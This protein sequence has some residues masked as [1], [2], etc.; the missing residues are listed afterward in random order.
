[1]DSLYGL[2]QSSPNELTFKV[3]LDPYA[4]SLHGNRIMV[5]LFAGVNQ[6]IR[7]RNFGAFTSCDYMVTLYLRRIVFPI[8]AKQKNTHIFVVSEEEMEPHTSVI[9]FPAIC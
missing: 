7:R 3:E 5:D 8:V 9:D 4:I 2:G 6:N 1:M